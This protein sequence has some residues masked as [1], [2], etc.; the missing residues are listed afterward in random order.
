[1]TSPNFNPVVPQCSPFDP[2]SPRLKDDTP[3]NIKIK[4]VASV[5]G[6]QEFRILLRD[7]A[8]G[9]KLYNVPVQI[10]ID[11][12]SAAMAGDFWKL[13]PAVTTGA[14]GN[15]N[16]GFEP[17]SGNSA[18]GTASTD[19]DGKLSF[20][21]ESSSATEQECVLTLGNFLARFKVDMTRVVSL[22]TDDDCYCSVTC[23]YDP[24]ADIFSGSNGRRHHDNDDDC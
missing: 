21:L 11:P 8:T 1:M 10:S 6:A 24:N 13:V 18:T 2:F 14:Y 12:R 9:R 7:R 5:V 4:R 16:K 22:S 3:L 19:T 17:M 20:R 15:I 23:S